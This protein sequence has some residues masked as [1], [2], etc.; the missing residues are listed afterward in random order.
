MAGWTE[1]Q[2]AAFLACLAETGNVSD[3]ARWAAVSR[4]GAYALR[5]ADENFALASP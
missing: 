1:Q 2:R 5:L 4:S 3:A